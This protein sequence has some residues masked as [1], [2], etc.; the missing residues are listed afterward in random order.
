[1]P[2]IVLPLM[3]V[4]SLLRDSFQFFDVVFARDSLGRETRVQEPD[5]RL[6]AGVQP[7]GYATLKL[8]PEGQQQD[9]ALVVHCDTRLYVATAENGA[10]KGRQTYLRRPDGTTWKCWREQRWNPHSNIGRWVFTKYVNLD[11]GVL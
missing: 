7:A 9:G 10:V 8:L 3:V 5:R 11:G 2:A 1:M 4:H 6:M